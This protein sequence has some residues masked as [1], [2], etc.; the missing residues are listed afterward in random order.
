MARGWESKAVE[1]QIDS[2]LAV[3]TAREDGRRMTPEQI[4]REAK[5]N[6]LMLSRTRV[7]HDIQTCCNARY[8]QQ[9]EQALA[10][11]DQQI[12]ALRPTA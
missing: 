9:L 10:Y 12:Q 2:A 11:L 3:R 4:E 7:L 8:R 6:G 1:S 5:L